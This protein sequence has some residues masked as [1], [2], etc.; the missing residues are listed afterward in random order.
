VVIAYRQRASE[1][2]NFPLVCIPFLGALWRCVLVGVVWCSPRTCSLR[3]AVIIG[4]VLQKVSIPVL[5]S[6]V[7]LMR[8][9]EMP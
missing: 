3:E 9:A 1:S 2:L 6:S 8:I 7:A 5:H 4:S